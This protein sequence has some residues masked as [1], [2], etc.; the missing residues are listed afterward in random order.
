MKKI[1]L[2]ILCFLLLVSCSRDLIETD[3]PD[4]AGTLPEGV[5][6][7]LTIPFSGTDLYEVEVG[8]KAEASGVSETHVHDLYVMIFDNTDLIGDNADSPK[9][10]YGRFFSYE[11]LKESLTALNADDNECWYVENKNLEGTVSTTTGAVKVST[12]TCAD[13]RLVVI[14]NVT[15]AIMNLDGED[16]LERLKSVLHYKEL[17]GIEVRLEQDVVNRKDLFLMKGELA[18]STT[19]MNWGTLPKNYDAHYTVSLTPVDAKVKFRVR[20]N[21]ENISAVTPVYWQVHN[22]P[23]RCYLDSDHDGG[24]SPADNSYFDSQQYYFEGTEEE[25]VGGDTYTWYTFC[26]YMLENRESPNGTATSYYQRELRDKIDSG[27][28]GYKGPTGPESDGLSDHYVDNGDWRFAPTFGTYVRFDLVLTL[29]EAG[30]TDIGGED[31]EG[32]SI[33]QALT[34]D[35]IFTV[36]LGD[37]TSS[38]T[39]VSAK[40]NDYNT[41]R[42]HS[43]TYDILVNNTRSIYAEVKN[44]TEVQS[45]Q[46]GF[47]LLTD[48]EIINA[49]CHYEY[50]QIEF[51][52]RPDMSQEKFSWYVKTPFGEG[53]PDIIYNPETGEFSYDATGLDYLWVKFGV[54]GT[55]DPSYTSVDPSDPNPDAPAWYSDVAG[56]YVC[57]YTNKRHAYPGDSHYHPEWKPGETVNDDDGKGDKSVPDLMDVTQLIQYIFYET[58]EEKAHR[59]S[60]FI[61]DDDGIS[62]V[63]VIRVTAFIDE[64][65]YEEN[66]LNPGSGTDPELWRKFVNANPR[67]MHI[68]SDAQSSRDRKSDV[69]LSSHS[70]IQQSIQTIYNIYAADLHSLWGTEHLD[71]MRAKTDGWPYW[72]AGLAESARAGLYNTLGLENGRLNTGYI[73]GFWSSQ[74]ASGSE[75]TGRTWATYMNYDVHNNIPELRENYQGMAWSCLTRNRDNNGDGIVDRNE[76]RWYLA[77]ANQLAGMWV[78]NESLSINARL[79]QPAEGQWR[80]HVISSTD[81]RVSWT[82]EGGGAT[83]YTSDWQSGETWKSQVEASR[84]ESVRCLRNIGTYNNGGTVTD[85]T[86]APYTVQPER[87]FTITPDPSESDPADTRY[88]F[89]FDRINPKSLRQLATSELPYHDQF[90]VNNCVYLKFQTQSRED[91]LLIPTGGDFSYVD[92]DD[93]KTYSYTIKENHTYSVQF[94]HLN[95]I[96]TEEGYNPFC[97]PGYR[98]PN[99]SEILLM[100]LYLPHNYHFKNS[101]GDTYSGITVYSPSRTYYDRGI[102]GK[103]TSGFEYDPYGEAN[104]TTR[105]QKKT[106]WGWSWLNVTNHK[107]HCA[108]NNNLM[109]VSRCVR[110]VDMT[111][112]IE[113]G[114]LMPDELYPGDAVPLSFSFYSSGATFISA[115]LKFCYTDSNGNYHERDIPVQKNPSGLE[116]LA[117]QTFVMPTLE[118]MGDLTDEILDNNDG[119]LRKKVKFKMTLRNAYTSRT[120]EQPFVLGNPLEGSFTVEGNHELLPGED[121]EMN[122]N[123]SSKANTCSLASAT[124]KLKYTNTDDDDAENTLVIPALGLESLSYVHEGEYISI[125]DTGR[126]EGQLDLRPVDLPRNASLELTVTDHGGSSKTFTINKVGNKNLQLGEDSTPSFDGFRIKAITANT[127]V[128]MNYNYADSGIE[129]S[130]DAGESWTPYTT[131]FILTNAGDEACIRGT[132]TDYKNAK[133]DTYGTPNNKP[134]FEAD[135]KVYIAGNIMSLLADKEHLVADAFN[136]AFSKGSGTNM[137]CIDID[138]SDPLLLPITTLAAR[139]YKNM[140]RRCTS[141]TAGPDLPATTLVQDC[142]EGMFRGC[143]NITSLRCYFTTYNGLDASDKGNYSRATLEDW[144]D[145][146]FYDS[147]S[148]TTTIGTF[149]CHPDMV[150]YWEHAKVGNSSW[151]SNNQIATIPAN[152]SVSEWTPAP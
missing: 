127:T 31:P 97:P 61:A 55:V 92:P 5:P 116:Y 128:T 9:K 1:F 80:A 62:T 94:K 25:T 71:E 122:F 44:D 65:Y 69:I 48:A 60:D 115:S 129:Y 72:P 93:G 99:H 51:A 56:G 111:G 117:D 140:F 131:P 89:H 35:A 124:L 100:S 19:E 58:A 7:T 103:N 11:H 136:G 91:E 57:P 114:I 78:G 24:A 43:Y 149:Y 30:I 79:Y 138:P 4:A 120:F 112:T 151:Y 144:L 86:E 145:K 52:Y 137:T 148:E 17:Q 135:K 20:V 126:G 141:L 32:M 41:Y 87:Y 36:H 152:W 29:T 16:P 85:I 37:F 106:G 147:G 33:T 14:A 6:V 121:K 54:N 84:G 81:Q 95:P 50:H 104:A 109:T 10:I 132:R 13:A 130:L 40:L 68:L 49:D 70:I 110:D 125:P 88:E 150:T 12:I 134:I 75:N 38:E 108:Q 133:T 146:W 18:V 46:E 83:V 77:S 82:E 118:A 76:V 53:G 21:P 74:T 63:P 66:P 142:Y 27:E 107:L 101:A 123:I 59:P 73:W 96:V 64:Y 22:T 90:N 47:L 105:E 3:T 102:Y 67:E 98:F 15:T 8:T 23:D 139:C 45:G 119:E 113:G 28:P 34:S 2:H 26:F 42:G 143:K 39:A